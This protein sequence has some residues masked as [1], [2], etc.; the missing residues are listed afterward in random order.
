MPLGPAGDQVADGRVGIGVV[1]GADLLQVFTEGFDQPPETSAAASAP[2][3]EADGQP[4]T[5]TS[6]RALNWDPGDCCR[7]HVADSV[8]S[9]P[10]RPTAAV[11]APARSWPRLNV[12]AGTILTGGEG[13]CAGVPVRIVHL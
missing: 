12:G 3:S 9:G 2:A 6:N 13:R 1:P 11:V 5:V 4:R 8:P 7:T 10:A